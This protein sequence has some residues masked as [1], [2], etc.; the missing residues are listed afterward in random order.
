MYAVIQTGG[1]QYKVTN[2][3]VIFIEKLDAEANDTV[4]FDVVAV[5]TD[6]G[7]KVGTP[8]VEGAKVTGEVV[9]NGKGK[10][11][12][13]A[14]TSLRRAKREQKVTDSL[15]HRLRLLQSKP[16][17]TTVT[18]F[19]SD[20]II[21]GF[22]ISGHSDFAEEGSDIVC[23][24]IS[25]AAYMTANTITEVLHINA[26]VTEDDGLMKVRMS[27]NDALKACDILSGLKLH[28]TALS[29]QYKNFIKVKFSEV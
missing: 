18:F 21:C 27:P 29:E 1:K 12:E 2:D 17:M 14:L 26:Q 28:L 20:D 11:S 25:S 22:E 15:T 5:G 13:F 4:T 10:K 23:A 8:L 24:A 6:D 9:K 16:K 7:I 19:K 3:E